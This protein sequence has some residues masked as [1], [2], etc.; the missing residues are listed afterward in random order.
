MERIQSTRDVVL[1][2]LKQAE[3]SIRAVTEDL[4]EEEYGWEP[5]PLHERP[6]DALLPPERKR[7]W[8][9][10]QRK[11]AWMYDYTPDI[12]QPSPFTTIAWIMNHAA[13]TAD[14]YLY[15]IQARRPEGSGRC[16]EELPVPANLADMRGYLLAVITHV[17]DFLQAIP[18]IQTGFE[19][20]R[21]TPAPWGEMRPT[22]VNLWGGVIE[23][24]IQHAA[25][26][27][28]RKD[29]IRYGY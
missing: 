18:P 8:R 29:H 5:L 16:W 12:V 6:A 1:F 19:L 2:A 11:G 15:C 7:V 13:Q 14:M 25:Q 20:N 27:A 21:L 9:V 4:T 10:Y 24:T 23:H 28:G 3:Q 17:Q 26:I 22:Y